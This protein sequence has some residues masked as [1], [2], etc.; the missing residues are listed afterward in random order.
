MENQHQNPM[1]LSRLLSS[2]LDKVGE[3]SFFNPLAERLPEKAR[4][5]AYADLVRKLGRRY[6]A[7]T[8][9]NFEIYDD[10]QAEAVKQVQAFVATT[11]RIG[12]GEGIVLFGTPGTGKD[13]LLA[14]AA[15]TCILQHGLSVEWRYGA[16]VYATMRQGIQD[17]RPERE[18]VGEL[19]KPQVLILSDPQPPKGE[20]KAYGSGQLLWIIDRRYG[21]SRSTWAT[22]NVLDVNDASE[23]LARP[24]VDRLRH[25]ALTIG[26]NWPSYRGRQK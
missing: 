20:V 7:C 21:A 15:F 24:L 19:L 5:Q 23:K 9:D 2:I 26:C 11:E 12:R 14:A 1:D 3:Q 18:L 6:A 8:F 17:G 25:G 10:N 4:P 13:H 22:M 16:E